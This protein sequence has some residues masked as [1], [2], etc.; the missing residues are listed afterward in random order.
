MTQKN[1]QTCAC[2]FAQINEL[3]LCTVRRLIGGLERH[4]DFC[5]VTLNCTWCTA[6]LQTNEPS[7]RV[8][9]C[10]LL[11]LTIVVAGPALAVIDWCFCHDEFHVSI[12]KSSGGCPSI[13]S[14]NQR[15]WHRPV[16]RALHSGCEPDHWNSESCPGWERQCLHTDSH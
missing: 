4:A 11:K 7:W 14:N 13:P 16:G 12:E 5:C 8:A 2:G 15:C 1:P 9:A 10:Q 3:F 6:H